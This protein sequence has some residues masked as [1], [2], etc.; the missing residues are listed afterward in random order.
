MFFGMN[1]VRSNTQLSQGYLIII[2][3]NWKDLAPIPDISLESLGADI[4]GKDKEGF[5]RWL[6]AALQ[7]N[8]EDRPSATDLLFD[9]WLMEGLGLER[10]EENAN[11]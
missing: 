10:K 6:R 4:Q 1:R 3:G 2:S 7:W 8:A 11:D 5:F 9:E